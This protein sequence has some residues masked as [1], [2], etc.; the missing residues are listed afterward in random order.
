[1]NTFKVNV[2]FELEKDN[3]FKC[4]GYLQEKLGKKYGLTREESIYV[5]RLITN[6]QVKKYG[7]NLTRVIEFKKER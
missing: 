6:Y 5:H 7:C 3:P 2:V 4:S 1:M